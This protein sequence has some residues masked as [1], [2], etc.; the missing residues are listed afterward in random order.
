MKTLPDQ[1][2]IGRVVGTRQN[3]VGQPPDAATRA[4]MTRMAQYRTRAPKGVF[5]YQSHE[6]MA[7]DRQRWSVE[8]VVER[9][10]KP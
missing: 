1:Q 10:R 2:P 3:R 6:Q 4:A 7:A 5:R 9:A 8:A